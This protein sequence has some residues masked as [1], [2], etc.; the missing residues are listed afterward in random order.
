MFEMF[1]AA[2]GLVGAGIFLAHAFDRPLSILLA[3]N[4]Q[5]DGAAFAAYGG[6][7]ITI[8]PRTKFDL[9]MRWDAQRFGAAFRS[10][11]ASPRVSLQF[12]R[13]PATGVA[14]DDVVSG[15]ADFGMTA[16]TAGFFNLAAKGGVKVIAAQ[17][18]EKPGYPL[19]A[20]AVTKGDEIVGYNIVVGGGMGVTPSAKKTFPAVA[21]R[22]C[23]VEPSQVMQAIEAVFKVQRDYGNREDRKLAQASAQYGERLVVGVS[24]DALNV[25]KKGREPVFSQAE[26]LA[27]VGALKPVDE[28]FVEES[29]E[30]KRHYIEQ[31]R[32]DVLVMGGAA[33]REWEHAVPKTARPGPR[34]SVSFRWSTAP[35]TRGR[36]P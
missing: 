14:A 22:L 16:F 6:A 34:I 18:A 28:V 4:L 33:Q 12:E 36:R 23:Y 29:L 21:K 26:Q 13:D 35:G 2:M 7:L 32:A 5:V 1:T 24:S 31:F 9:G 25:A 20:I 30:L 8:T 27:I 11:Q 10:D 3:E 19:V 17:S 15:D